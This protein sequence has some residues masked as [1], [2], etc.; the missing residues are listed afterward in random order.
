MNWIK[1]IVTD[2]QDYEWGLIPIVLLCIIIPCVVSLLILVI[3][4]TL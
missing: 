4:E 3:T 1:N 2:C